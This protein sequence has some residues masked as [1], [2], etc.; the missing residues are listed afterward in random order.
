MTTTCIYCHDASLKKDAMI[1]AKIHGSSFS[2]FVW[3]VLG[4]MIQ[5]E[6]DKIEQYKELINGEK[7]SFTTA[8]TAELPS[9]RG[10]IEMQG[11]HFRGIMR[12][13]TQAEIDKLAALIRK[14]EV[15][16]QLAWFKKIAP[17]FPNRTIA[18]IRNRYD[19]MK[20]N[21]PRA[22]CVGKFGPRTTGKTFS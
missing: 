3:K 12:L 20:R 18:G 10:E 1:L 6:K 7:S 4:K 11:P 8:L 19:K 21:E 9:L 13:W 16:N 5:D 17:Q 15:V 14:E 22:F 2:A